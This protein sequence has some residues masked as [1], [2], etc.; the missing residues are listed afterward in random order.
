MFIMIHQSMKNLIGDTPLL[1]LNQIEKQEHID[2]EL[3]AKMECFNPASSSKDRVALAMIEEGKKQGWILKDTI[4]IEPTS[5][6]T[7]IGLAAV[8][9]TEGLKLILTMPDTMSIERRNLVKAFGAEVVLTPGAE[10]MAGSIKKAEELAKQHKNSFIPQQFENK[11]NPNIHQMTTAREIIR[12]TGGELDYFV[13][14]VGTGGTV[15]GIGRALKEYN[16]AIKVIA[17][18]PYSSQVLAGKPAGSHKIQGIGANFVPKIMDLSVVDE[19]IP[20]TDDEAYQG[21][22]EVAR[23]EG[24]LVGISSGAALAAAMKIAKRPDMDGKRIIIFF[25]D[26]GERYISTDLYQ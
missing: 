3:V 7:G 1:R 14:C 17:V 2:I 23:K 10:G 13:A 22:R 24:I 9:A 15:T 19:I 26:S 25:P 12:D 16:Q 11:A 18:E 4:I 5:G 20:I 8:C 6:N 21:A